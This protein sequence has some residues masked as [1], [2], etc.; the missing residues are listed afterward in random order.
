MSDQADGRPAGPSNFVRD[1]VIAD[2]E[3]GRFGGKVV[4]RFPPEPNGRLHLGHGFAMRVSYEIAREFGGSFH[5]R[6]DDT[7]PL[8]E[9]AEHVE[10]QKEDIRWLGIDWGENLFFA[11]DYFEAMYDYAIELVKQGNAYVCELSQAEIR[12]QRGTPTL[13]GTHS[14]YR[15]R[16]VEENL[17]LFARM[18]SGEIEQGKAVL[19][20][21]IDM[22][23][24]N[25]LLRDP[26]IYRI[27]DAHHFRRG[28]EWR[29]YPLYDWA[30]GLE[31]SIEGITHSLCSLEFDNNRALYDWFLDRLGVHHPKQLEFSRLNLSH[32]VMS[33]RKLSQLVEGGHVAGWD[34]P[35]MPT[36]SGLRRRGIPPQAIN[37]FLSLIS[38]SK[39]PNDAVDLSLLEYSIRQLLNRTADRVMAVLRPL[40][41][42]IDNYPE[43][44]VEWLEA[45]NNP[46][47]ESRGTR[48]LPFSR[49]VFIEREDFQVD[50]PPKY[51]RLSPG[52]EIRLKHAYLITCESYVEDPETGE[53][54][55]VHCRYDP[56][57]RGG[58]APDGRRVRGTSH[59]V[60]AS[61]AIP[62]EVRLYD[63]LFNVEEP[64]REEE[65]KTFLD[66]LNPE[67]MTVLEDCLL[68]PGLAEASADD[69]RQF[70]R[71]GYFC[72]DS[73]ASASASGKPVFNQI[74]AL[75]DAWKKIEKRRE[76]K[77]QKQGRKKGRRKERQDAGQE[78]RESRETS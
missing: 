76:K 78:G 18:K 66:H 40:K 36:L 74:V 45:E 39:S 33:K 51:F 61:H 37:D 21:K 57:S 24:P 71:Q 60:S 42:I 48:K 50:P 72:L 25:L 32:T 2:L 53:I 17:E 12:E 6:F 49:E 11:S 59:W 7:N 73:E 77:G 52:S 26:V 5:L 20:A 47:D 35:R 70:M 64:A 3:S 1:I 30:H 54:R 19:R 31:D 14:P 62:A 68:E 65:G 22:S 43:D 63:R 75:K 23:A 10:S 56:E 38:V 41:L 58:S 15:D 4:T 44:Q 13:E 9:E 69:R 8:T 55:E 29:I 34:D 27:V 28:D 46:E 16:S 67:S